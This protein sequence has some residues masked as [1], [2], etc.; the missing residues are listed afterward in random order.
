[1][2]IRKQD[3][4]LYGRHK[5]RAR[6]AGLLADARQAHAGVLVVRGEAGI[7]K[8]ALLADAARQAGEFQLLRGTGVESE[9]ELAFAALHQLLRPVLDRLDL[10]PVPQANALRGAFGLLDTQVNRFLAEL[11]VLS[12]LTEVARQRPVLCLVDDAQRLDRAS[13]DALVFVAR[14]L[15]REPIV[16][17]LAARDDDVRQF[18]GPGLPSLRLGGLDPEIAGQ[19]LEAQAGRLA[20][21]VRDRLIQE[22]G[23]N[24]LA[25]E[26]LP[27]TLTDEQLAGRQPLP[28]RI[29]LT[30]RLQ[31]AF[32]QR[33]RRLPAATQTLLLVAAAE[34][35][36]ELATVLTAGRALAIDPEA[37]EPAE[38]AGLVCVVD[39]QLRFRHPLVRSAVYDGATFTAR[40][41]THQALIQALAGERQTDRRA[42]HLAAATVGPDEQVASALELSGDRA[43]R[44]GGPAAAAAALERAA[45]L[46]PEVE[47]R[48]RRLVAAAEYLWEAGHA[49]RT[50]A[51]L[52]QAEPLTAD[53]AGRGR[54]AHLRGQ[55]ELAAGIP[56]TACTLLVQGARPI[57]ES[58]PELATEMLVLA[59]WAALAA[60][61]LDRIVDEIG[62][63]ISRL[64]GEDTRV[65]PVA[66]SLLAF[67]LGGPAPADA[68]QQLPRKPHEVDTTWPHPAFTW[69]WPMLILTEPTGADV[70]P[71]QRYASLVAVRRA[72]GTVSTL[73]VAL[74]NLALAE[75][76]LG[77]WPD[78][79]G[80][81]TE[82]LR[83]ARETGQHATA[84]YFLV[85]LA[86]IAALQGRAEDC[87]RLAD[88][89][90]AIAIPRRL[91]VVAAFASWTLALLDL[92][93][94]RPA[95]ALERLLA[96]NSP[97]LP[98]A[99]ATVALLATGLLVEAAARADALA[100][101]EP[102]V[103]G[104][105]RWAE[106]DRRTWTQV[107]ARRSRALISQ[108]E[109]AERHYQAA[110]GVDGIGELP[111]EVARTEL[112]YGEWL[113]RARR[114]ADA[115]PHLRTA[116]ELF[117]RL[118]AVPW[119]GRARAEL[120]ASGETARK[121]DPGTSEQLT[122][123]ERQVARLAAQGSSNRKIADQLFLSWHT[124]GYHLHKV[125]AK[126]GITSRAEL[127]KLDLD[128]NTG[129]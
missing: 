51:L 122:P 57:L 4:V 81:A 110:L 120:R 86:G 67:G 10:L 118:G 28:E 77:H 30:S 43:R 82:G 66:D 11:G 37:L 35:T 114:R 104:F 38:Q 7:G 45:A 93:E 64:P 94:W 12:L 106:W 90:L 5:E 87:R 49:E 14:R 76:S 39:A 116:L 97:Q 124:V 29:P 65:K 96:L 70:T 9:V 69:V 42:W 125:Y 88:E 13:G 79:M 103:A 3:I 34:D 23:G 75:A 8:S 72:A 99:H 111:F 41:A 15:G 27:A 108:G 47:A 31:Q 56:A 20:P 95:A 119:A 26:E 46:T 84:A 48:A 50:Q 127:Q 55:V 52:D 24:P 85:M 129:Y 74:A 115:R 2:S 117:E 98:T 121:R 17:L 62:P 59:T 19:L 16:L 60:N 53:P 58:D 78:A 107:V 123:Q 36:G 101:M 61:Q 92:T 73:T 83:L 102:F 128:D 105:E 80:N 112:L 113:R 33:V 6:I 100:G 1:V 109:E 71:E 91:A 25:L 68:T 21:Q 89:A 18:E 40:Q 32:L 22:T 126:L 54:I 63:A 44:R